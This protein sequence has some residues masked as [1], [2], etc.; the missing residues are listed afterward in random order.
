MNNTDYFFKN[1]KG[2]I[3]YIMQN[4]DNPTPL[5]IQKS[6]YFLWAFYAATYGDI[7]YNEATE[8]SI[9]SKYPKE[10]FPAYFEARIYGPVI[11][12]VFTQYHRT[13][14]FKEI[15]NSD[16]ARDSDVANEVS[17]S[18]KKEIWSF[19]DDLLSQ[20]NNVDDFGLVERSHEDNAWKHAY[21][22]SEKHCHMDNEEIK[23]DYVNY[24]RQ[25]S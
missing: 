1:V 7:D 15:L 6:L 24:V 20:I 25:Q 17:D 22:E 5:K 4:L 10:L 16:M 14:G 3:A 23:K 18:N 8:F 13:D 2:L 12:S 19:I 21:K 9:Q 11:S